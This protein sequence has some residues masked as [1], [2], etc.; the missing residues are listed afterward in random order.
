MLKIIVYIIQVPP[1]T[2]DNKKELRRTYYDGISI[3]LEAASHTE[4]QI[5]QEKD[6]ACRTPSKSEFLNEYIE[7]GVPPKFTRRNRKFHTQCVSN[8]KGQSISP[9]L[10]PRR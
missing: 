1:A 10:M 5:K 9:K 3:L 6:R 4:N 2:R 8:E 7:L